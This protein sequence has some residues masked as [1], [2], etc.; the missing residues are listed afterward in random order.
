MLVARCHIRFHFTSFTCRISIFI[1]VLL[2]IGNWIQGFPVKNSFDHSEWR[3]S[4]RVSTKWLNLLRKNRAIFTHFF[5][6]NFCAILRIKLNEF[7]T[8]LHYFLCAKPEIFFAKVAHETKFQFCVICQNRKFY[9]KCNFL[10]KLSK[11]DI[12]SLALNH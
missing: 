3:A 10:G 7:C 2:F 12:I 8:V 6:A 11:I 1:I 5:F 9:T 4:S